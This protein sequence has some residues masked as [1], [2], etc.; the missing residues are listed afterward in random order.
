M[1]VK[2]L[3]WTKDFFRNP[4]PLQ[5]SEEER[6]SH[7]IIF[8]TLYT[9]LFACIMFCARF[10]VEGWNSAWTIWLLLVFASVGFSGL[11]A[12]KYFNLSKLVANL[13]LVV[14]NFVIFMRA[15]S[16]GGIFSPVSLWM[17]FVPAIAILLL[18]PKQ[19]IYWVGVC[20]VGLFI[21]AFPEL[22]NI[23]LIQYESSEII[24]FIVLS[25][26]VL[27]LCA[28]LYSFEHERK[29][30]EKKIREAETKLAN[31]HK[32]I[33]LGNLSGGM[34]HEINNPLAVIKGHAHYLTKVL[35]ETKVHADTHSSLDEIKKS[36]T[37]I[38][39]IIGS[40]KTFTNDDFYQ[41]LNVV[42]LSDIVAQTMVELRP[43]LDAHKIK[44][45]LD[46]DEDFKFLGIQEFSQR[47]LSNLLEN[48]IDAIKSQSSPWIRITAASQG[49]TFTLRITDSG[50]GIPD[51]ISIRMI[52]PFFS[53]KNIGEGTGL[54]L[55]VAFNL[56]KLQKGSIAYDEHEGN[57]S[58]VLTFSAAKGT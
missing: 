26:L 7:L 17:V 47:I 8:F 46:L 20:V 27:M 41:A 4:T 16:T 33:A 38:E 19:S 12:I 10:F 14:G 6:Q 39:G 52:D 42:K 9:S 1:I 21:L 23:S 57:T 54:G 37:R 30:N 34:A 2:T 5:D 15:Y 28:L 36:I 49:E 43:R 51:E 32:L 11:F 31:S 25:L 18:P 48:S 53:T 35:D 40:L 55:T 44:V 58:F 29:K 50:F 3:L 56:A 45:K 24:K 13:M 22:F